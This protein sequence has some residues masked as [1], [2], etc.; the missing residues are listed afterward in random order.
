MSKDIKLQRLSPR[1]RS[2]LCAIQPNHR[3]LRFPFLD[4]PRYRTERQRYPPTR[5][6][7]SND[8]NQSSEFYPRTVRAMRSEATKPNSFRRFLAA[9]EIFP[10]EKNRWNKTGRERLT[11]FVLFTTCGARAAEPSEPLRLAFFSLPLAT[12]LSQIAD[13]CATGRAYVT[14]PSSL[15]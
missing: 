13:S 3:V 10:R 14:Y 15:N 5:R 12:Q 4:I 6:D 9:E 11:V 7:G 8:S 1:F 2:F